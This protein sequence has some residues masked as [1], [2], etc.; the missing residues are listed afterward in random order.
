MVQNIDTPIVLHGKPALHK[1]DVPYKMIQDLNDTK[2]QYPSGMHHTQ[3]QLN[4]I[5]K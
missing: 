4:Y 5:T 3:C 2:H 1:F